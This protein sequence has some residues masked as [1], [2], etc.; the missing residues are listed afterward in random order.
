MLKLNL[1][2]LTKEEIDIAIYLLNDYR[3]LTKKDLSCIELSI[4]NIPSRQ[5]PLTCPQRINPGQKEDYIIYLCHSPNHWCQMI[6]Q[7]AH[8]LGHFF[9]DCYPEMR[10]FKWISES[11]CELFSIIFLN[12]SISFF[13]TFSPNYVEAV[14]EYIS[15]YLKEALAYTTLSCR[16]TVF[17]KI[18][19]LESDPT[20]EGVMGRPRNCF[21]AASLFNS[22]GYG[23][24]GLSAICLFNELEQTNS[25][26]EFFDLWESKC[27]SN[28]ETYFVKTS[29]GILGL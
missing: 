19:E 7:L 18:S 22:L 3:E 27:R 14:K 16:E 25:S 8:E 20:E 23:G 6:Y 10:N 26:R 15:N 5:Y 29:R 4:H 2:C 28:D 17:Q 13:Q 1:H 11:L 9:M 21:I 12:R 24:K